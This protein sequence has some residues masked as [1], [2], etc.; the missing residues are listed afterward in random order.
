MPQSTALPAKLLAAT[1]LAILA[2]PSAWAEPLDDNDSAEKDKAPHALKEV[3]VTASPLA[4]PGTELIQPSAVLNGEALDDQRGSTIGETVD[5]IPGVQSSYFGAGVGRPIIRGLEGPRVQVLEGGISSLDLSGASNDHAVTIDPFLADQIEVLKGPSTLLYGAGAIGGVVNV[6]DGRVP[7][8]PVD[9]IHGRA[10][11]EG[12]SVNDGRNGVGR[13]DAGNGEFA[14]HADYVRHF[15]DD[16]DLP[17][18]GTLLNS[19]VSTR[20]DAI[21][22]GYTGANAFAGI[23]VSQLKDSYG[24]PVGPSKGPIDPDVEA[25]RLDLDQTRVDFKAGLTKPLSWLDSVTLRVA[26]NDYQHTEHAVDEVD[27]TL[28]KNNGYESRLEAVHA[29]LGAWRGAFGVQY[30]DRDFSAIGEETIVPDTHIR[31]RGIF[32]VEQADYAPFKLQVGARYDKNNLSPDGGSALSF[33]A[34]SLS[35]GAIWNFTD[36]WHMALNL[37]RAQRAPDEE[38]LFVN[39]A[40]DATGSFEVGDPNL[41]EETANQVDLALHFHGDRVQASIGAYVNRFRNFIYLA[42]T[43]MVEED[44]PLRQWSQHDARFHGFEG[45][46]T[47]KLADGKTGR[48]DLHLLG[49]TVRAELTDGAGNL[50]RIA[51][52][53]F[54]GSLMW[55]RD[56]WRASLGAIRYF[57][58]DRTAAFETPTAGYTLVNAHLS[59]AF[60]V[61]ASEWE[62][63]LDGTNLTNQEA[64]T[65]TSFLKDRAPLPGRAVI[66]GIRTFF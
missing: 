51:P 4:R 2:T 36:H 64:R 43:G 48:F 8:Q 10:Q 21:G 18:G 53:R 5:K 60:N 19:D 49:D 54:G 17:N 66:F 37:D 55:K 44:L 23:S 24:I 32:L 35:G 58:Q 13:V 3:T 14:V 40:H 6:V 38:S 22:I 31:E 1:L 56:S 62:A 33:N 11:V 7:E 9:G 50:P 27:G 57:K 63:F 20:S 39:G 34:L 28:F 47:I 46:A 12:N 52:A 25:V 16:Y 29:P 65:A 42:E 45:E 15:A 26:H 61:G 59:R 41:A 30:G